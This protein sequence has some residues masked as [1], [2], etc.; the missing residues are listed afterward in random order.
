MENKYFNKLQKLVQKAFSF[1]SDKKED[2]YK[3]EKASKSL[4]S[5]KVIIGIILGLIILYVG[6][7]AIIYAVILIAVAV[8]IFFLV[9]PGFMKKHGLTLEHLEE[10]IEE[11]KKKK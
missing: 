10:K 3:N 6:A 11:K 8:V 7:I 5:A 1:L 4:D 2:L 9:P